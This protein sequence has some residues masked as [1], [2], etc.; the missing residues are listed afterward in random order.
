M[1]KFVAQ[2]DKNEDLNSEEQDEDLNEDTNN[3]GADEDTDEEE[4]DEEPVVFKSKA[5]YATAVNGIVKKRLKRTEQKYA[6]IVSER[7]TLK[8]R[9]DELSGAE[10]GKSAAEQQIESLSQQVS[11]LLAQQATT[12]RNELVREIAKEK[13]LPEEFIPRV[14]GTDPDS[15]TE[16]VEELVELLNVKPVTPKISK[17]TKPAGKDGKGGKGSDGKG[18]SDDDDKND[19]A[20][21]AKAVGRYGHRPIFVG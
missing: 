21:I 9:V 14:Q 12:H 5:E 16:D 18:G 20:E 13:G 15:I 6:P 11:T 8:K 19:P 1:A 17:V 2:Q 3:E 7:D 4:Q 10:Q